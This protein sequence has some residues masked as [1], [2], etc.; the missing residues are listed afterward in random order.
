MECK[1]L[2]FYFANNFYF[3]LKCVKIF[4][5]FIRIVKKNLKSKLILFYNKKY[6]LIKDLNLYLI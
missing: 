6:I 2:Y 1:F 5:I 4:Y 3:Y